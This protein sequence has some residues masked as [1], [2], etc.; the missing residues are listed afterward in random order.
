MCCIYQVMPC[1]LFIIYC[2]GRSAFNDNIS[3]TA[4]YVT[5]P[6]QK[7]VHHRVASRFRLLAFSIGALHPE[8]A[9][10]F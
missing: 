5:G 2:T 6:A 8:R 1:C 7:A 9:Q 10:L 4:H 3:Q